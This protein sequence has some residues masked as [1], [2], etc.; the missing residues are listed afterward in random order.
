VAAWYAFGHLGMDSDIQHLLPG[1]PPWRQRELELDRAFPQNADLLAIVIDARTPDLAGSA[2]RDL[3]ERLRSHPQ[4]FRDVREPDGGPFFEQNG[5]L[6][7]PTEK[8]STVSQQLISAQPLIGSLAHDP[9]LRGLFD[10]LGTFV[11]AAADGNVDIAT[12]NPTLTVI[13][14]G[15]RSALKGSTEPMSWQRLMT[16]EDPSPRELR[17]FILTRPV[18]DFTSLEPGEK[19]TEEIRRLA[20]ELGLVPE[21]GVRVRITGPVALDDEQFATLREGSVRSTVVSIIS[22]CVILFAALR[23]VRLVI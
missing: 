6:F 8:L 14:E 16:G 17:R 5:L 22:V 19:A 10:T 21:Q 15:V 9:S 12:I 7:L 2:G 13:A 3:A 4:L 20:R 18:L 1:D 11:K 23:S